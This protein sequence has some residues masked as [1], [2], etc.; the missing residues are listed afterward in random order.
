MSLAKPLKNIWPMSNA[1]A[2]RLR[3][4]RGRSPVIGFVFLLAYCM[5]VSACAA[6]PPVV[7]IG[8]VGPFTGRHREIGYDV[9]YSA[10]LAVREINESGGI[11]PYRVALVA[12]DDFGDPELARESARTLSRDPAMVAIIGHWL[13]ETTLA[14][15]LIYDSQK[16]AFVATGDEPYGYQDPDQLSPEFRSAY[17]ELTPFEEVAGP[18]AGSA[19]EAIQLIMSAFEQAEDESGTIDRKTVRD[20]LESIVKKQ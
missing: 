9:I 12:L 20:A 7:K 19:Y 14:S 11:G 6:S 2:R 1:V 16:I 8:L 17:A 15:G 10:R 13:P 4:R 5:V 18:Y 3:T